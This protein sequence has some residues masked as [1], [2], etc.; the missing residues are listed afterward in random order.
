MQFNCEIINFDLQKNFKFIAA[1]PHG[2]NVAQV[3]NVVGGEKKK[4]TFN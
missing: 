1:H 4:K 2:K 3:P